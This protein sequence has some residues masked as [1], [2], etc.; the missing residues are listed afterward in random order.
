[1]RR[2]LFVLLLCLLPLMAG[3]QQP[4]DSLR[5]LFVGNSFT[6]FN[7]MP[8]MV[9]EIA[10]TQKKPLIVQSITKGGQRF[11][12]HLQNENLRTALTTQ[13]WD[14]VVLQEQ[15]SAPAMPTEVVIK[16][17]YPAAK[18]LDSLAHIGS[19]EVQVVF[20]MTWA[21]KYGSRHEVE[22]Y[23]LVMTYEG[24]Q[25]R[26]KTSY[27]EMTYRNGAICAPVGMAWQ[28]VREERPNLQLYKQDCYHPSKLGSYLIAN[29][30]YTTLFPKPYQTK[31]TADFNNELAEYLQQVAQQTVLNNKALLGM[32]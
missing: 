13:H 18:S 12:G 32:E 14:F 29:V 10:K 1:M 25:E 3:A 19:P 28:Q 7:K 4:A 6:Y 16:E 27:L 22:G 23:P 20:Y 21:H 30:I 9:S 15:S 31:Y 8:D 5:V 24:M 2:I 11:S 26:L 17:V